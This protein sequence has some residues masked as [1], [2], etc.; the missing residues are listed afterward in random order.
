MGIELSAPSSR[1]SE[2]LV[3]YSSLIKDWCFYRPPG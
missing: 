2:L 1:S 3:F